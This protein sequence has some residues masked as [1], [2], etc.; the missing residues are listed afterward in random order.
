MHQFTSANKSGA[1]ARKTF[2]LFACFSPATGR[3]EDRLKRVAGQT[4][5]CLL[6]LALLPVILRVALLPGHPAP[7]QPTYSSGYPIGQGLVLASGRILFGSAWAGV[8]LCTAAFCALAYWMLRGWMSP[9]W[10][11]IGG[12]LA[13]FEFGPLNYWTNCYVGGALSAVAG[14]LTFGALPRVRQYGR[15]R[16]AVC[17]GL[18]IALQILVLPFEAVLLVLGVLLYFVPIAWMEKNWRRLIRPG[19]MA[20]LVVLP[21]LALSLLQNT[22]PT[23]LSLQLISSG[24]LQKQGLDAHVFGFPLLYL[25]VLA[26]VF[27][28]RRYRF[29]WV[30]SMS[31]VLILSAVGAPHYLI[32]SSALAS[33][34]FLLMAVAGLQ[35][36]AR[37]RSRRGGA[38]FKAAAAI[39]LA[40]AFSFAFRWERQFMEN[41]SRATV[42]PHLE[43]S[44]CVGN[45]RLGS[46]STSPLHEHLSGK[47]SICILPG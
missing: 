5:W 45:E 36:I 29:I 38:G 37:F 30:G 28:L 42:L 4:F 14:C 6:T 17:L 20:T 47:G 27:T 34:L 22:M 1:P 21:A 8:L 24:P 39:L 40:C 18:G 10:S 15:G 33:G 46:C 19:W 16:D 11:L 26:F 35:Q 25:A 31:I 43:L 2:F 12:V 3:L 9:A 23:T 13:V 41:P 32:P 7:T 44:R